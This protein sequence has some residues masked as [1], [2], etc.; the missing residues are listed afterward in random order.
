MNSTTPIKRS[1]LLATEAVGELFSTVGLKAASGRIWALLYLSATPLNAENI[2]DT[3]S[4]STGA[5]SMALN[6]LMEVGIIHR[7]ARQQSRYFY[8]RAETEMWPLVKRIFKERTKKQLER[9]IV[10]LK[11]ALQM[12]DQTDLPE[13]T[14]IASQ[15]I[16]LRHLVDLGDFALVLADALM[17]RTRVEMKAAQKWLSVSGKL[18][19]EPLSR[20]RRR[21]NLSK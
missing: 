21:I 13:N 8:Y 6:E 9:P 12:L 20:I 19:G 14:E 4:M 3:L 18:G 17:E 16:Q 15:V 5:V 10:K 7:G 11:D 1:V 2:A